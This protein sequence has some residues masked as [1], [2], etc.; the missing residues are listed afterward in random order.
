MGVENTY[1][2]LAGRTPASPLTYGRITTDD[3]KGVI[4]AYVGEGDLTDDPLNTFGNR[5]VAK[6]NEL[7]VTPICVPK[8]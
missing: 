5:A 1:G 6:I 4:K 2:A 8:L 7:N 3:A